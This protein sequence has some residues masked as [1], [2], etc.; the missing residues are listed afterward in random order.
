MDQKKT[1][2]G[3]IYKVQYHDKIYKGRSYECNVTFVFE[4]DVETNE[5]IKITLDYKTHEVI[6]YPYSYP[7][8]KNIWDHNVSDK[9][10]TDYVQYY[11]FCDFPDFIKDLFG[12]ICLPKI[13][14]YYGEQKFTANK[15]KN[16]ADNIPVDVI[17][18]F[19][20]SG[21]YL[22]N[23]GKDYIVFRFLAN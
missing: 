14:Y 8:Y 6:V 13:S 10:M 21:G 12:Q 19:Q 2:V 22:H 11:Q 4:I 9:L 1:D 18:K 17:K 16:I 15:L 5:I 23:S 20:Q 3:K 7:H